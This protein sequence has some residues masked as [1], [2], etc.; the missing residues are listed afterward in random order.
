[1]QV[2]STFKTINFFKESGYR[3]GRK[4]CEHSFIS[5]GPQQQQSASQ[6][7]RPLP[8]WQCY[9]PRKNNNYFAQLRR[10]YFCVSAHI[11]FCCLLIH[12]LRKCTVFRLSPRTTREVVR[13]RSPGTTT[14]EVE[15]QAIV[16]LELT[17]T[18]SS[19]EVTVML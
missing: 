1:M 7:P 14:R 10:Y 19:T 5:I 3:D 18:P 16:T 2:Q 15:T 12:E 8:H 4:R 9:I 6:Q 13:G 11:R 17:S